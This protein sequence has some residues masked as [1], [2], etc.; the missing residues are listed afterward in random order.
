MNLGDFG[1]SNSYSLIRNSYVL[2]TPPGIRRCSTAQ[3]DLWKLKN[4]WQQLET[5]KFLAT[6]DD[7]VVFGFAYSD[8]PANKVL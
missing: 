2:Q 1:R 8:S 4:Y 3:K 5:V 7:G 6:R